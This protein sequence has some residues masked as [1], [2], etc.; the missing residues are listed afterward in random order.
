MQDL[1]RLY[2]DYYEE[3][4]LERERKRMEL[5]NELCGYVPPEEDEDES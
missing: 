5:D 1:E 4:Q 3:M 2:D